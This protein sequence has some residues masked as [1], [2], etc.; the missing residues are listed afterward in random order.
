MNNKMVNL[1]DRDLAMDEY[2][3]VKS[4]LVIRSQQILPF[5]T[6]MIPTYKRLNLVR[7]AL[8]SA[9]NQK[10]FDNYEIVVC[11][12]DPQER[13]STEEYIRQMNS[14]KIA[15]YRN[16]INIGMAGNSR[17][18]FELAR[19]EWTVLLDD[20]DLLH[21]Y[22]LKILYEFIKKHKIYGMVGMK[23]ITIYG[24]EEYFFED[25]S[26]K[27][28]A[29]RITKNRFFL[30]HCVSSPGQAM[31]KKIFKELSGTQLPMGDQVLQYNAIKKYELISINEPLV[32][33]RVSENSLS[34]N[35][36]VLKE[37]FWGM[38]F[39]WKQMKYD[40]LFI[41]FF[42][43]FFIKE[44]TVNYIL[45]GISTHNSKLNLDEVLQYIDD[46][47]RY[48][49]VKMLI[50]LKVMGF[51]KKYYSLIDKL[52]FIECKMDKGEEGK[53]L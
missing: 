52:F 3:N 2:K 21:P 7:Q 28:R 36:E 23:N 37:M 19:G 1:L 22:Y 33:Y 20:D 45:G 25:C 24:E 12:N 31:P 26:S 11:D 44:Y 16:E 18:V 32:A 27:V 35:E 48:S 39:L 50:M 46:G 9:V 29:N 34:K 17:R 6:I 51:K 30:G 42:L 38:H 47:K 13:N 8:Q 49:K 40:S 5:F 43:S 14:N 41:Y 4:K 10:E 15:Y 53:K